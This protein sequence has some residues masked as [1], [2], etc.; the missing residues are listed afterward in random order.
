MQLDFIGTPKVKIQ[1]IQFEF[2]NQ[3]NKLTKISREPN[4]SRVESFFNNIKTED[5]EAESSY[6]KT[7]T[8]K[9][10]NEIFQRWLFA[11]M[12]VHTSWESNLN[13]YNAIKHWTE[14]FNKPEVLLQKLKDSRV[15][16]HNNRAK[17]VEQFSQEY[18]SK[19]ETFRK[20]HNE[21][22]RGCRNRLVEYVLGL[23]MAK[24]SFALEMCYPDKAEIICLD[25][26]LFQ[27]YGLDQSKD[28][29]KY[30]QIEKHW[31]EMSKMWNVPSYIARCILWN[32]KQNK[33]DS[34]YWS[35][36]LEDNEQKS[37]IDN[38]KKSSNLT[39]VAE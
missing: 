19:P 34:R 15:G 39:T 37:A 13:G 3:D 12:S 33:V 4:F 8:P 11:F 6:W 27:F 21:T 35:F 14:W 26:H 5:I 24:V 31:I 20:Q 29:A 25:T 10:S 2:W 17:F 1:P 28:A 7:V 30:H 23:G 9:D 18:W 16:L 32:K 22:W 36:V 38:L